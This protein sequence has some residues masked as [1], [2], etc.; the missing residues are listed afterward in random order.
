MIEQIFF[1][2]I[3]IWLLVLTFKLVH[4]E[5]YSFAL[6]V[7]ITAIGAFLLSATWFQGL[8]KTGVIGAV[9]STLK[10]YGDRLDGFQNTITTMGN[11]LADHQS[12]I[13][14]QQ[15]LL[16]DQEAKIQDAQ[17][18]IALQQQ[19]ITNQYYTISSVQGDL[20]AAQTNLDTQAAK[21][22]D[23]EFLV[24]N[25]FS[26]TVF[27]NISGD[28]TNKAVAITNVDGREMVFIKLE[29]I[30][31][32][33][34]IQITV[35]DYAGVVDIPMELE[36]REFVTYKNLIYAGLYGYNV[37]KAAFYIKYVQDTRQTNII[38]TIVWQN[39]WLY[40]DGKM[41]PSA[42]FLHYGTH[43]L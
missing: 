21:I 12:K 32:Q 19:N 40:G 31:I 38:N 7:F 4:K 6:I 10:I 17:T 25:L 29:H 5:K 30:P 28:D 16:G 14:E 42:A 11:E 23:V 33:E 27:E 2:G 1:A 34:S 15:K 20:A 8:M 36:Q 35:N 39:G 26:K 13:D 9:T 18:N 41:L 3:G 37:Q 43:K 24:D 22:Q